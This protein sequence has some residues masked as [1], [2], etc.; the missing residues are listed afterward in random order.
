M[1]RKVESNQIT[2]NLWMV[3]KKGMG[4]YV[5][6]FIYTKK[7]LQYKKNENVW[8]TQQIIED[9]IMSKSQSWPMKS[10]RSLIPSDEVT[11]SSDRGHKEVYLNLW[12]WSLGQVVTTWLKW[13][14]SDRT[15]DKWYITKIGLQMSSI[16][17]YITYNSTIK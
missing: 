5:L 15:L 9:S 3:T 13:L 11:W 12:P 17:W 10:D 2:Q 14:K 8:E 1:I 6:I 16:R 7:K 4:Q